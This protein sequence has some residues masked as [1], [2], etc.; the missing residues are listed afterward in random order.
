MADRQES[1]FGTDGIRGRYG[2]LPFTGE[3]LKRLGWAIAACVGDEPVLAAMDTRFSGPEILER[4]REGMGRGRLACAGILPT[5]GL[6]Y[7]VAHGDWRYG[8]MI[9]ASHNPAEDNGIKLFNAEGEKVPDELEERISRLYRQ[10]KPSLPSDPPEGAPPVAPTAY[11][12]FLVRQAR[13]LNL[14]GMTLLVDTANGAMSDVAPAVLRETGARVIQR[15][16]SP[17]GRNINRQCGSQFPER[18]LEATLGEE[19]RWGIAFD[20]DG[21]RVLLA[22]GTGGSMLDGDD[23]LYLLA[24]HRHSREDSFRRIVVGTVMSNLGLESALAELGIELIRA[25][26]GDRHVYREMKRQQAELGGEPSG[27][28][29]I[30]SQQRSGDGLLVALHFF[31][32]LDELGWAGGDISRYMHR[33]PQELRNVPVIRK[34]VLSQWPD[35]LALKEEFDRDTGGKQAR[36]LIRYSGT[37]AKIRLMV[38][39]EDRH[40][41]DRW[42]DRLHSFIMNTIGSKE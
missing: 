27:H 13:G 9:T 1:L 33:F 18:L 16:G 12:D 38:E 6:S 7:L 22:D 35:F 30:R 32:A 4:L 39:A 36:M 17:D 2:E 42:I 25:D 34:P 15:A 3:S 26:V 29:I 41:V 11:V 37:E 23:I 21:D 20:G 40:F 19:A 28:V 24:R 14:R 5:P 31:K 8:I 10:E